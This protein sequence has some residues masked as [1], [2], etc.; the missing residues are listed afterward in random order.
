MGGV[1]EE[2]HGDLLE[3]VRVPEGDRRFH[4]PHDLYPPVLHLRPDEEQRVLD[5]RERGEDR[6]EEGRVIGMAPE[7]RESVTGSLEEATDGA[8]FIALK[9]GVPITPIVMTG[10]ENKRIYGNMKKF[11]RTPVTFT[12]GKPFTLQAS[13]DRRTQL[14]DGTRRIM[15]TLAEML[16]EEYRGSYN[17]LS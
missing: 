2:V 11:K 13:G 4:L 15:E 10:T 8:A 7:G 9:S 14:Q 1:H 3:L 5:D 17:T 16:P 12:V 6:L